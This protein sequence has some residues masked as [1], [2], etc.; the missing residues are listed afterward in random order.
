MITD[1]HHAVDAFVDSLHH[2][3]WGRGARVQPGARIELFDQDI[4]S[5][6]MSVR[7]DDF[8]RTRVEGAADGGIHILGH[9]SA[10]AGV[11]GVPRRDLIPGGDA[12]DPFHIGCD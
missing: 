9:L 1:E 7:N 5:I 4:R 10:K 12:G 8:L 3:E 6:P 11:L 2:R